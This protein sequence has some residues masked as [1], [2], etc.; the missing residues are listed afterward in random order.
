MVKLKEQMCCNP[1]F[2]EREFWKTPSPLAFYGGIFSDTVYVYRCT[3][4][5]NLP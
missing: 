3:S 2:S 5:V 4:C 1:K